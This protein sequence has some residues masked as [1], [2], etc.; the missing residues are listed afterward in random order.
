MAVDERIRWATDISPASWIG[1]RLHSFGQDTGSVVPEGFEAY[2]RVF[3]PEGPLFP[4]ASY[5]SWSE[6]AQANGRI[7]HA[8]MQFHMID[9]PVG[10]PVPSRLHSGSGPSEGSP[11]PRERE[12]LVELL[13]PETTAPDRCWFCIWDGYGGIDVS[14]ARLV[15]LPA[16]EYA[17]YAGPIDLALAPL[18]VPWNDQS[19]NLW[20]PD[21][22]T[23]VVVAEIDFAWTYV[24]GHRRLIDRIVADDLLEA[25]PIQLR[26]SPFWDGDTVNT[27][28]NEQ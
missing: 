1:P 13:K 7:A 16:R 9:R 19:P 14:G 20:W 10:G 27:S 24:G 21:D 2:C 28:E 22:R 26:D 25:F 6:I 11:P 8:G 15:S 18:D 5:R 4:D 3:H 12:R 17:L 23:W